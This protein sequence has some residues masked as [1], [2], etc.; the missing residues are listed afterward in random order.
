VWGKRFPLEQQGQEQIVPVTPTP[1]F[2]TGI[3]SNVV[4]LRLGIQLGVKEIPSLIH[5]KNPIPFSVKNDTEFP[6]T[7]QI[8]PAG[9]RQGHWIID[10]PTQTLALDSGATGNGTFNLS[11]T[12]RANTDRRPI[13]LNVKTQGPDP[14]EFSVYDEIQIGSRNV[15][16]EFSSQL[17]RDGDIEVTQTFVNE[18]DTIYTYSCQLIVPDRP[19]RETTVRSGLGR[20]E[21]VY[22][23]RRG[24]ELIRS[25][26]TEMTIR[27]RSVGTLQ[28]AG[29]PMV[30]TIPLLSD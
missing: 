14:Q 13:R 4:R 8:S 17:N 1:V 25:G 10:P 16:M 27:A 18:T 12:A 7:A 20:A 3:S 5:Q 29:Q 26:V 24:Q 2:I 28:P 19:M 15:Y 11:L 23:I 9:P 6:I 22:I 30:Y 21:H